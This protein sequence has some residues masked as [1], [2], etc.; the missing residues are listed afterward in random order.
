MQNAK[1]KMNEA[2]RL[3]ESLIYGIPLKADFQK[4]YD[5]NRKFH[6]Y[7]FCFLFPFPNFAFCILHF[8]FIEADIAPAE[9]LRSTE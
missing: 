6:R 9:S 5:L 4:S 1:C 2:F 3:G 8:A 7:G